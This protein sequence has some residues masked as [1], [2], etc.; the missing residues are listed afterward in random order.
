MTA[1]AIPG[2][3]NPCP[4]GSGSSGSARKRRPQPAGVPR[5][6]RLAALLLCALPAAA[7]NRLDRKSTRLNSSHRT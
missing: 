5:L 6:A 7:E 4:T 1:S 2:K 3:P